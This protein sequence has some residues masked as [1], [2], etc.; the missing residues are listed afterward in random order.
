MNS[1]LHP[2]IRAARITLPRAGWRLVARML[3]MPVMLLLVCVAFASAGL[4]VGF[5]WWLLA[6]AVLAASGS[7]AVTRSA[8]VRVLVNW[9]SGWYGAL[10]IGR[11]VATRTLLLITGGA[12][13]LAMVCVSALLSL[14]AIGAAHGARLPIALV[15][16]DA[17][18]V[19]GTVVATIVALRSTRGPR[20]AH[21]GVIRE[22]LLAL[23]WLND[24]RL[25]HLLDWQRRDALVRWRAG[26]N[27]VW[28]GVLLVSLPHGVIVR[29]AIG[30][31]LL[32]LSLMWLAVVMCAC[33]DVTADAVRLLTPTPLHAPH[34]RI[35]SFRYPL[36]ASVC[37]AIFAGCGAV[38][39]TLGAVMGGWL[40]CAVA[41]AAWPLYRIVSVTRQPG[42]ST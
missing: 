24:P 13:V 12:L 11:G 3:A 8:S 37:A 27:F 22:P 26:G 20:A 32:A 30:V 25:P 42:G 6:G 35:A 40:A 2:W 34:G 23:G 19:F 1:A 15:V 41:L 4:R 38:L 36:V 31:V 21:A 7:Y 29:M 14:T 28:I 18:L 17:G 39:M 9:H 33:A 10:P 5:P 16:L